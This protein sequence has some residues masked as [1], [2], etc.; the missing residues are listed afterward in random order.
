MPATII[1]CR[2]PDGRFYYRIEDI[3]EAMKRAEKPVLT[4]PHDLPESIFGKKVVCPEC[5]REQEAGRE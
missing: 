2:S 3:R 5:E 4:C 1:E